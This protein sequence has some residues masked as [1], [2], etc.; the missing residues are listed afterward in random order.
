MQL[1]EEIA[2]LLLVRRETIAVAETAAGGLISGTLT[3]VPGASAWFLGGVVPY[4][5]AAKQRWLGLDVT[6]IGGGAVSAEAAP[7]MASAVRDALAATWGLAETG[8]AGPQ[9]GRRS[10]K[11]AG[12]VFVAIEGPASDAREHVTGLGGRAE[13]QAAFTNLAL[14]LLLESLRRAPRM[15]PVPAPH[16]SP[17]R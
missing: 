1:A 16:N 7:R 12:L 3:A 4:A 17:S 11:P 8:I 6:T 15:S 10:S 5:A 9:T 14:Q 13:N 2:S